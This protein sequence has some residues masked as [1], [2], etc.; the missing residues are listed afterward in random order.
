MKVWLFIFLAAFCV[1]CI[2]LA[3]IF[4][5]SKKDSETP[6]DIYPLW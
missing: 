1:L 2:L 3:V 4:K 5:K 6:D